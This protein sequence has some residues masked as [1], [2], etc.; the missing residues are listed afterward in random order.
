[1]SAESVP[2]QSRPRKR[3]VADRLIPPDEWAGWPDDKLLDLKISELGVTI[4]GSPLEARIA[5]LQAELDARGLDLSAAFLVIGRM[6][7]P[8]WGPGRGDPL[9]SGPPPAGATRANP[10]ARSRGRNAGVV[11]EDPPARGRTRDRQRLQAAAAPPASADLRPVVHAVPGVLHAEAV[12]QELRPASGQLVRAEP[13]RR[14]LRR[15]VCRLAQSPLRLAESLRR[16]AG[17]EEAGV[18]GRAD[19]RARRE[20]DGRAHAPQSRSRCTACARRCAR[21]TN[22]SGVTTASTTRISTIGICASCSR[23]P[24]SMPAT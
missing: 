9:L 10:D 22:A 13:S 21:T 23:T 11:H 8:R 5:E 20:A 15:D 17:A 19:A 14:R 16:L 4:E 24:R 6:V 12:Q 2:T 3:P 7:L 18:H 1:M